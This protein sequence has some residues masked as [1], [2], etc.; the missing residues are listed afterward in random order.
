[1]KMISSVPNGHGLRPAGIRIP[2]AAFLLLLLGL[3][4]LGGC[5][6]SA[7]DP[8]FPQPIPPETNNFLFDV[9]GTG[10]NNVY[11]CGSRGVMY[12][13]DGATWTPVETGSSQAIVRIWGLPGDGTLYAVGHGGRIWRNTGSGWSGMTSPTTKDL[14]AVG[15]FGGQVTAVGLDGTILRLS[16]ST[17]NGVPRTM[18]ILDENFAPTDTL[19]TSRDLVSV[20]TVNEFF[21]GGAYLDP[22]FEGERIGRVGSRGMVM[23]KADPDDFPPPNPPDFT[24]L[25]DWIL[26]PISGEQTSPYEWV[27]CTTSD[28]AN[29]GRNLLG[30]SEGWLFRLTEDQG[31]MVWAKFFPSTTTDPDRGIRDIWLDDP[32]NIYMVTDAGTVVYQT[33][34]YDFIEGIGQR[35]TLYDG[36]VSLHGIW[37]TGPDNLFIVG[38]MDQMLLR[39]AHDPVAGTFTVTEVEIPF[40]DGKSAAGPVVGPFGELL[41]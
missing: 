15:Q 13:F 11:A 1:M 7:D 27:Y 22:R 30:T 12:R 6:D 19:D 25:P 29:L 36:P 20:L 5:S 24:V 33:F 37:G 34:D 41:E 9:F 40:P 2:L 4:V 17:W 39:A 21:L 32:G 38:N 35:L 16:G 26:R 3:A 18:W 8:G 31:R 28:P 14:F 10:A 23:T